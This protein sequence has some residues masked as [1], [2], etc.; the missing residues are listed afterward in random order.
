[1]KISLLPQEKNLLRQYADEYYK[2]TG[3]KYSYFHMMSI[4][5]A[6]YE[7]R[8]EEDLKKMMDIKLREFQEGKWNEQPKD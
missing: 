1:M 7:E 5:T 8:F 2:K 4:L 3:D 6:M